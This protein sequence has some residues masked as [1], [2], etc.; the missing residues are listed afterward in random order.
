MSRI[1]ISNSSAN[2][3]KAV[4]IKRWLGS[5]AD[6]GWGPDEVFSMLKVAS[7]RVSAGRKRRGRGLTGARRSSV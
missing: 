3:L 1:V 6:Y 4:A 5:H 2:N 7:I